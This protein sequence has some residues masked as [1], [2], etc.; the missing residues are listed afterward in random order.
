[1]SV[2]EQ[3]LARRLMFALIYAALL[4]ARA[5]VTLRAEVYMPPRYV[6]ELDCKTPFEVLT[7]PASVTE[8]VNHCEL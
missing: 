1:M 8:C 5:T 6:P 7:S 2:P 4:I 3:W